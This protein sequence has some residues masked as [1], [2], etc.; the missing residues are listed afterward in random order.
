LPESLVNT[1]ANYPR[2][3]IQLT[4][5]FRIS[6]EYKERPKAMELVTNLIQN[7]H[8][9]QTKQPTS[10]WTSFLHTALKSLKLLDRNVNTRLVVEELLFTLLPNPQS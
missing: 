7:V 4:E 10:F 5:I 6:E 8:L 2:Q 1:L 9:H 3:H